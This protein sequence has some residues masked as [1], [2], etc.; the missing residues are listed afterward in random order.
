M[1]FLTR[2]RASHLLAEAVTPPNTI[3]APSRRGLLATAC[4]CCAAGVFGAAALPR[5]ALAVTP[6][7]VRPAVTAP[8]GPGRRGRFDR[9]VGCR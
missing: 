9:V 3:Q 2:S 7:A 5:G 6:G 1:R 8:A 4:A